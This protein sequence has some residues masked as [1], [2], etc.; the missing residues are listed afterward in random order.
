MDSMTDD[1]PRGD[2]GLLAG[3]CHN[4]RGGPYLGAVGELSDHLMKD[5]NYMVRDHLIERVNITWSEIT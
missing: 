4:V 1:P 5:G 2:A 3:H